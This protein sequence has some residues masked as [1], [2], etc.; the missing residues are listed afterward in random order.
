MV[1]FLITFLSV[2]GAVHLYLFLKARSA[3]SPGVGLSLVMALFLL[4]MVVA[5]IAVRLLDR[6]GLPLA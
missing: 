1:R 5:P 3:L 4:A 2:Y 6:H